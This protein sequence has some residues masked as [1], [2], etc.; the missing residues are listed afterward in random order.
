[1]RRER[2]GCTLLEDGRAEFVVWAPRAER[3]DVRFV[4]P[5]ERTIEMRKEG[6]GY[7]RVV[8]EGI[9]P[10][11]L[12]F[13]RLNGKI[14]RP[15][16]A[17]R[18]QPRGVHGPSMAVDPQFKWGDDSWKGLPLDE[19]LLYEIHV[20]T[21]TSEGTFDA[22]LP[23]LDQL[24]ELGITA[25]ELMPVAQFPGSRNWGYDGVYPYAVQDSYGGPNALK[26][27]VN[28]CHVR[29]LAVALDVVYNHLGPEGNYL[30]DFGP[31]FTDRYH[32]PWGEALNFDGPESDEVRRYF[33]ENALNWIAEFHIDALRL[34]AVHAIVDRSAGPFL[35]E[36]GE[37][38]HELAAELGRSV[39]VIAESDR[40]DARLV[41]GREQGGLGL[42]GLWNDDLHHSVHSL[43]TG[44]RIGYYADFGSVADLAKAFTE[45]FVYS[46]QYSKYR[47]RRHGNSAQDVPAS[48]FVVFSQNHDQT[49]NRML[50]ERLT[51]LAS[52]EDAKLAAA[53]VLLSP[54][55]PLLFMGEEYGETAPFL[56]FVSHG[57]GDLIE[58]VRSG[59]KQE[60]A[61]FDWRGEPPDPQAESTFLR[62]KLDW[63]LQGQETHRALRAFYRELIRLR[64][65]T[66]ALADRTT[67]NVRAFVQEQEK[68]LAII[69]KS[70]ESEAMIALCFGDRAVSFSIPND[71]NPWRK[72]L[73]SSEERWLGPGSQSPLRI[74]GDPSDKLLIGPRSAVVY[75]KG[76]AG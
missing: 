65:G 43:I 4:E 50:G 44:E 30:S 70:G 29:G 59:R 68:A 27:L 52:L 12:Y 2:L 8:A 21:F 36:L 63:Q 40:N 76:E 19:Y 56:Y 57:D 22:I 17:S 5:E 34:D 53:S 33:V 24:K 32:T 67:K 20:G 15:D 61:A 69:R 38:V 73:D 51:A 35:E 45:G 41:R 6:R 7:H 3:V 25:L 28:A 11:G 39:P 47:R 58:A 18:Y 62:S 14:E 23:R 37:R 66:P 46:G 60:F 9:G 10:G 75:C 16:P 42:D 55:L 1:M 13:F 71:G 64:G 74:E 48:R 31:Y 72:S 49:G 54:F 26:R